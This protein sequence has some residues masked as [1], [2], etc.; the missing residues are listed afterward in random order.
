MQEGQGG[1]EMELVKAQVS[2]ECG[3]FWK[4]WVAGLA[5]GEE[6]DPIGSPLQQTPPGALQVQVRCIWPWDRKEVKT[7]ALESSICNI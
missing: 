7:R 2:K 4:P 1:G 3:R 5:S 6:N